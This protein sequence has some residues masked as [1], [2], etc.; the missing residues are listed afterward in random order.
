MLRR[1]LALLLLAL[2]AAAPSTAAPRPNFVLFLADDLGW[3]DV[4]FHGSEI[5][6]PHLDRL[7]AQGVRLEQLYVQPVCSPTRAALLT[8][9]YPLRYGLQNAIAPD[10]KYGLPTEERTLAQALRETGYATV[11]LGKWH[12]GHAEPRFLPMQRGFQHHYGSLL[13]N[14]DHW[15][16]LNGKKLDWYRDGVPLEEEGYTTQLL[17]REAV[18]VLRAHDAAQP[19]FLMVAFEATHA[20]LQAPDAY[21]QRYAG[22]ASRDRRLKAAMTTC[23][24]DAVGDVVAELER[25]GLRE[26]TL[27]LFASDNGGPLGPAGGADN[28]A[29]RGA[30]SSYFEGGVRVAALASWPGRVP[31]GRMVH[32]MLHVTD[33]YPTLLKLAGAK[34]AQP[35]PLDG[36]DAWAAIAQG[37]P[38]PRSEIVLDVAPMR[39]ALRS[40]DWKLMVRGRLPAGRLEAVQASLYDLAADPGEKVDLV[41]REKARSRDL[42]ARLDAYA[43]EAV[44]P[45]WREQA[46]AP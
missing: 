13:G 29:W 43:R 39:G 11:L 20:P 17:A 33:L 10:A 35:L 26:R 14:L 9:R 36:R 34:L 41:E 44:P 37:G 31:E 42:L 22:I 32:A 25:R 5:A 27:I 3:K 4:G 24:D 18:R 6:T 28:G 12:L 7:A 2:G 45:L 19:L 30:K 38:S 23:L 40:G 21:V 1:R 8:G 16:H 46:G 15:T